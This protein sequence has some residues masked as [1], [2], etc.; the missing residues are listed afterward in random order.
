LFHQLT[1]GGRLV[2]IMGNA[3]AAEVRVYTLSDGSSA[4]S[5][6]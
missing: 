4:K 2:A 6:S 3:V 5:G 1:E